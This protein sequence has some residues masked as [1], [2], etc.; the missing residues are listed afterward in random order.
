MSGHTVEKD[1]LVSAL[2]AHYPHLLRCSCGAPIKVRPLPDKG[3]REAAWASHLADVL[4]VTPSAQ[5]TESGLPPRIGETVAVTGVV[6]TVET[7]WPDGHYR[8]T[9]D[10]AETEAAWVDGPT[11]A[12][13]FADDMARI[14][15]SAPTQDGAR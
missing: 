13:V 9:L 11:F 8:I 1:A 10:A 3:E 4:R 15:P 5:T 12:E 6:R 7:L 2:A 14:A